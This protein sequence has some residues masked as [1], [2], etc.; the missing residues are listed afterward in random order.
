MIDYKRI[1]EDSKYDFLRNDQH[2]GKNI[3]LLV[4]GGSHSY[5]TNVETSDIDIRGVAM[6]SFTNL[7]GTTNFEQREDKETDTVIYGFKK[8]VKLAADCNPN[9]IEM[10]FVKPEHIIY[11]NDLGKMLIENRHLFLSQKAEYTFGDMLM[12]N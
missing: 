12:L 3:I 7:I 5:G 4:V 6:N 1:L 11:A 8:F 9:I 10:L 2:L